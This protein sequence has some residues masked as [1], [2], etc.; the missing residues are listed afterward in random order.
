VLLKNGVFKKY[1]D[2]ASSIGKPA[3]EVSR[4]VNLLKLPSYIIKD[5]SK[6]KTITTLKIID[7]LRRLKDEKTIKRMYAW[8]IETTPSRGDFL[9]RVKEILNKNIITISEPRKSFNSKI[10]LVQSI[11]YDAISDDKCEEIDMYMDEILALIKQ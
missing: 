1:S 4:T 11:D 8:Y 3:A 7:G 10:A 5:I 9:L 6:N 2:L